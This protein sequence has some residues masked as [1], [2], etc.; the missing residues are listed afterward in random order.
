MGAEARAVELGL[1]I[2]NYLHPPYGGRYGRVKAFHRTGNFIEFSG[3]TPE[4]RAGTQFFPGVVGVDVTV[5]QAREAARITAINALGLIRLAVGSLDNVVGLSRALCFV[6]SP[7]A[8]EPLFEVSRGAT[9]LFLDVFG[10]EIGAVGR[11]SLGASSLS[12]N[13]C[14]ELLLSLEAVPKDS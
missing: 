7:P 1:D 3:M 6:L 4:T 10:D 2:P 13:N 12:R 14:F 9:D 8:F 5:E 11:A